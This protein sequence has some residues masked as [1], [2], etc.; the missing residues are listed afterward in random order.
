MPVALIVTTT[1]T[2]SAEM[3]LLL[4][5]LLYPQL[6]RCHNTE[7][8]LAHH[9]PVVFN[10]A[11]TLAHSADTRSKGIL[12]PLYKLFGATTLAYAFLTCMLEALT[13]AA[14]PV[15]ATVV[16]DYDPKLGTCLAHPMLQSI[17]SNTLAYSAI[18]KMGVGVFFTTALYWCAV[19]ALAHAAFTVL[20]HAA[21]T[22]L[23]QHCEP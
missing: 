10:V 5:S 7:A 22:A 3:G 16:D 4:H 1:L 12:T 17:D 14:I 20:A 13:A 11:T 9:M 19:T 21:V 18:K 2:I 15:Q 6:F 8:R 23:D